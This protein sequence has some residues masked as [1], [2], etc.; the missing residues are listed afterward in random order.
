MALIT[1]TATPNNSIPTA[2]SGV[3]NFFFSSD[4]NSFCYK[5]STGTVVQVF[6]K[7]QYHVGQ[8]TESGLFY[9][10][11][12]TTEYTIFRFCTPVLVANSA[13]PIT[14]FSGPAPVGTNILNIRGTRTDT[15]TNTTTS[16]AGG[17]LTFQHGIG[18]IITDSAMNGEEINVIIEFVLI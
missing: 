18:D 13:V 17:L 2:I 6:K 11:G 9:K 12:P 8:I 4:T 16:I 15:S 14:I 3:V 1:I 5:D 7:N 10:T